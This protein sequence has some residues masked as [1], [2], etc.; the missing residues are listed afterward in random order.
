M[1]RFKNRYLVCEVMTDGRKPEF[2]QMDFLHC[3]K[4]AVSKYHGDYGTGSIMTS[5]FGTLKS[6]QKFLIRYHQK[7]LATSLKQCKTKEEKTVVG[8]AVRRSDAIVKA[9][10]L[11]KLELNILSDVT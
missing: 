5:L 9:S 1:V 6:C 2:T 8:K 10:N 4:D 7:Q 3:L 11:K